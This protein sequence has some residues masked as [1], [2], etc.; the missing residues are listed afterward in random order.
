MR[1][2]FVY[3][4]HIILIC[5]SVVGLEDLLHQC[6]NELN[7]IDKAINTNKS[8]CLRIGNRNDKHCANLKTLDGRKINWSDQIRYLGVFLVRGTKFKCS[9]QHH[10]RSFYCAASGI[11]GKVGRLRGSYG[12]VTATQMYSCI[13]IWIRSK[14]IE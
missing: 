5:P 7:S 8:S 14:C 9:I 12:S 3:A 6:E 13:V 2:I 1:F 10:K 11:F 4:D